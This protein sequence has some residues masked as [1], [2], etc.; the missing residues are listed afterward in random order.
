MRSLHVAIHS[1]R[2]CSGLPEMAVPKVA[3]DAGAPIVVVGQAL[4]LT[5]SADPARRPFEDNTGKLLRIWLGVDDALFYNPRLFYLTALGKCF[6]GKAPGGGDLPP[7]PECYRG[8][9]HGGGDW[10]RREL[11]LLR[12]RLVITLGARAFAYFVPSAGPH[13]SHVGV[14]RPWRD[15]TLLPL[16]HPSG[17]NRAWHARNRPRLTATIATAQN[18]VRAALTDGAA[19]PV[20]VDG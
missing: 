11:A 19:N 12:P 7:R 16:P 9:G 14:A 10:L 13:T 1:C 18:L 17:A 2:L 8:D 6:P 3:G 15:S 20:A 5:E 4:S